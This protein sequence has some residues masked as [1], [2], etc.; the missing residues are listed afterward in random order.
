MNTSKLR[1][2]LSWLFTPQA[3]ECSFR[4]H[5]GFDMFY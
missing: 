1:E 4:M 3:D 2:I 5:T